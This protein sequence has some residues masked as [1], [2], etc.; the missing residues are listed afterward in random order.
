MTPEEQELMTGFLKLVMNYLQRNPLKE[1][2][3]ID[4]Q[5]YK[6]L[7]K[8]FDTSHGDVLAP[9]VRHEQIVCLEAAQVLLVQADAYAGI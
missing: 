6:S 2:A 5:D 7:E 9:S 4:Y 8:K 3:L 1:N